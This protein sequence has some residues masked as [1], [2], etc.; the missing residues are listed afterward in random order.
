[1]LL[2]SNNCSRADHARESIKSG[3]GVRSTWEGNLSHLPR[4]G[5]RL[6][7]LGLH[8]ANE[9]AE[10]PHFNEAVNV[11]Q[12]KALQQ[13]AFYVASASERG[14]L[15][16]EGAV[17]RAPSPTHVAPNIVCMTSRPD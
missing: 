13:V 17:Y 7:S 16:R 1:M 12:D 9:Q 15:P 8:T 10:T 6:G 5:D 14:G 11:M 2:N 4:H 3:V